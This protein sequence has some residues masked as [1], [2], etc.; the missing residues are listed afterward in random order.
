[1]FGVAAVARRPDLSAALCLRR[2]AGQPA[3]E[4]LRAL[5]PG[6]RLGSMPR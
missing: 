2:R 5:S 4:A 6:A 1:V 3:T